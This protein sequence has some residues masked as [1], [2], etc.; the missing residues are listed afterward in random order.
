MTL[1]DLLWY[2]TLIVAIG[3]REKPRPIIIDVRKPTNTRNG[4]AFFGEASFVTEAGSFLRFNSKTG[5]RYTAKLRYNVY[6]QMALQGTFYRKDIA[7][8]FFLMLGKFGPEKAHDYEIKRQS[9]TNK[10]PIS[11]KDVGID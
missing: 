3:K 9:S 6:W 2:S 4:M 8:A 11:K 5:R 1:P 10:E 7:H